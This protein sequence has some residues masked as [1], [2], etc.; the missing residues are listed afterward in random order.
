MISVIDD[1]SNTNLQPRNN[2]VHNFACL[3][4]NNIILYLVKFEE[5][6]ATTIGHRK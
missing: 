2:C 4:K 3:N 6:S 5:T 1:N